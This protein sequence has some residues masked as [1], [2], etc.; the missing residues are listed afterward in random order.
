MKTVTGSK[1]L[2]EKDYYSWTQEMARALS[3]HRTDDI[4]FENLAEE[5][6]DLGRR[7]K[8]ELKSQFERLI[9]HLLKWTYTDKK[10]HE[11]SWRASIKE[12]RNQIRDSLKE[13]PGLKPFVGE[14]YRESYEHGVLWAMKDTNQDV[15]PKDCPWTLEQ[16]TNSEFYPENLSPALAIKK[17]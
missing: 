2:Y 10:G 13:N 5:V 17:Q 9:A 12:S 4:D 8:K 14:L 1:E 6:G 15:F 7:E 16:V 11:T 3:E